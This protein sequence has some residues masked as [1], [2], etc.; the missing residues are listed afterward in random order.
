MLLA[1]SLWAETTPRPARM[2]AYN[3]STLYQVDPQT[4]KAWKMVVIPVPAGDPIFAWQE[5]FKDTTDYAAAHR[6]INQLRR[7]AR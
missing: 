5:L 2:R 3:G 6:A 7:S 1:S 4:G